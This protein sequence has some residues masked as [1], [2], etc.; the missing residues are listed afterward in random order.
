MHCA[1][2]NIQ[3][4][5]IQG[6]EKD[7]L[8][9]M[10]N[11]GNGSS[12]VTSGFLVTYTP[13]DHTDSEVPVPSSQSVSTQLVHKRPLM[14]ASHSSLKLQQLQADTV[15]RVCISVLDLDL[16][17][18]SQWSQRMDVIN[19]HNWIDS[20]SNSASSSVVISADYPIGEVDQDLVV[21][22]ENNC[23]IVRTRSDSSEY[24]YA[25]SGPALIISTSVGLLTL[26]LLCMA[27]LCS[28]WN[29]SRQQSTSDQGVPSANANFSEIS[30]NLSQIRSTG[31]VPRSHT[32][33]SE[34]VLGH[35]K[36]WREDVGR[37]PQTQSSRIRSHCPA[38][39]RR[40]ASRVEEKEI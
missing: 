15:Y 13:L 27:I 4:V 28:R 12:N 3:Q 35:Y 10:W 36:D 17:Q 2:E 6:V 37:L 39:T 19:T 14:S 21:M 9:V 24:S 40:P 18:V 11:T 23:A 8:T 25:V 32:L 29:R 33:H 26:L 5:D 38:S 34:Q 7:S 20:S 31:P 1:A 16:P 30:K 22:S